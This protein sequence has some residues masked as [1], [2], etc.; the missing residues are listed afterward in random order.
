MSGVMS[1]MGSV[2]VSF[3]CSGTSSSGR[4]DARVREVCRKVPPV[5]PMRF[6]SSSVSSVR[7]AELSASLSG[8]MST[9]PRQPRR[10][11]MTR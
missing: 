8:T 1:L 3:R 2:Y 6:T 11:P 7:H 4:C 10:M 9:S 5:R